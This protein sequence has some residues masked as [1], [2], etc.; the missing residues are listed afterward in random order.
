MV[1]QWPIRTPAAAIVNR[2]HPGL[3]DHR[4]TKVKPVAT[5]MPDRTVVRARTDRSCSALCHPRNHASSARP[6]HQDRSDSQDLRDH[7]DLRV[8]LRTKLMTAK[9]ASKE[10][11]DHKVS[12]DQSDHPDLPERK[13]YPDVLSKSM[14]PLDQPVRK[15]PPVRPGPKANRA[16]TDKPDLRANKAHQ[17]TKEKLDRKVIRERPASLEPRANRDQKAHATIVHHPEPRQ[18]IKNHYDGPHVHPI[19]RNHLEL[20]L[21]FF[22]LF[23]GQSMHTHK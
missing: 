21:L 19:C 20:L 6:D 4:V 7:P 17:E 1:S 3:L 5:V 15:E 16:E 12:P 22:T 14:A 13:V 18:A 8:K 23:T 10:C 9:R 11:P 2:D